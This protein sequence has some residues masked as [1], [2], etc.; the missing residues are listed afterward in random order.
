MEFFNS[1]EEVLEI[2]LTPYGRYKV[3]QGN[4]DPSYYAFFDEDIIYD[5]KWAAPDISEAQNDIESRIQEETPYVKSPTAFLGV[6]TLAN[7]Q[8]QEILNAIGAKYGT[9]NPPFVIQDPVNGINKIYSQDH[10]Q[11]YGD[12]FDFLATPLGSSELSSNYYPS[13]NVTMLA[14][15]IS[16]SAHYLESPRHRVNPAVTSPSNTRFEQI[17]QINITLNYKL[18]V[19]EMNSPSPLS[20]NAQ[21]ANYNNITFPVP[22][23]VLASVSGE[24]PPEE[25]ES[26]ASDIFADG[27]YFAIQDGK[28]V[29]DLLENNTRFNKENFEIEVF[30]S[31]SAFD[32][33]YGNPMQ[34]YFGEDI[35]PMSLQ[36]E[37]EVAR[38]L[39][40]R[41][42]GRI[43]NTLLQ[44]GPF[45][46]LEQLLVDDNTSEVVSTREFV[47]RDLYAP[48]EDICD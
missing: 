11:P 19:D 25:F 18:Y 47:V 37:D 21:F 42:D 41:T 12:K 3:S 40:I 29:L 38:Y 32:D 36:Q 44:R 8:N 23:E 28:I 43:R 10:L 9:L 30:L 39:T 2:V 35:S 17:P 13:W 1:K 48:E 14:G 45:E 4:W 16:S 34:L 26:I 46:D 7:Y 22:Q 6:E 27:T 5:S 24:I 33:G 20:D 31:G 15:E